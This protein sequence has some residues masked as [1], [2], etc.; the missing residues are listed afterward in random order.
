MTKKAIFL[1][2]QA[3]L[4]RLIE[5]HMKAAGVNGV[6]MLFNDIESALTSG[7][8]TEKVATTLTIAL[9]DKASKERIKHVA[10]QLGQP[11]ASALK[12]HIK[13]AAAEHLALQTF[14][15]QTVETTLAKAHKSLGLLG[16]LQL[17]AA[18]NPMNIEP[19]TNSTSMHIQHL[20]SAVESLFE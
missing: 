18:V 15:I 1:T 20:R 17:L 7:L 5:H 16:V 11:S 10:I 14:V 19:N 13:S 3:E 2:L 4:P 12:T 9:S 6:S 8:N